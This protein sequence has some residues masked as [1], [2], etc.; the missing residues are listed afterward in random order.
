MQQIYNTPVALVLGPD[1]FV[2]VGAE[3]K[4]KPPSCFLW[5]FS[6]MSLIE[7]YRRGKKLYKIKYKWC[8][9]SPLALVLAL[10]QQ[11]SQLNSD[12]S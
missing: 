1:P 11:K 6:N 12:I 4:K 7:K 10:A 5:P 3:K 2:G 8:Y 9:T